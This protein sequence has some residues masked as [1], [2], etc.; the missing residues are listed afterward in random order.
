MSLIAAGCTVGPKY[1]RASAPASAHWDVA[2]PWRESVPK[3][4]LGK[5]DWWSVFHD[6]DLTALESQTLAENQALKVSVARL[7]QARALAA[8]QIST[9]FPQFAVAPGVER[10]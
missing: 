4:A 1:Q 3:D 8:V 9:Q 10:Q 5:G 7:E 2:E 6:D